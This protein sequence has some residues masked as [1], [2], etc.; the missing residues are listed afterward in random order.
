MPPD[1]KPQ[2]DQSQS[3]KGE[4]DQPQSVT[5]EQV[6]EIV[7]KAISARN[8]QVEAKIEKSFSDFSSKLDEKFATLTPS[9]PAGESSTK[10]TDIESHPFVKGLMKQM[11][12]QKT[13]TEQLKTERDSEKARSREQALRSALGDALT[14]GGIDPS[15]VKHAVG[16]LVDVEKRVRFSDDEGDDLVFK[17]TSGDVDL[18]TGLKG[19]LKGDDAKIFLPPRGT[20]GAGDRGQ[21]KPAN[22]QQQPA[23]SIGGALL[24][25]AREAIGGNSQQ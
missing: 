3:G 19:W 5:I 9:Q 15:R 12:D 25:M 4:G 24:G 20:Q 21:G 16:I 14:K 22:G 13:A 7:N 18:A 2:G 8:K 1:E 17:D 10:V 11:A 6:N 23:G